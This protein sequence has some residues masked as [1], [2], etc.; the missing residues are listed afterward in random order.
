MPNH[1]FPS[2]IHLD[3][4]S[5]DSFKRSEFADKVLKN[6]L[7]K[8]ELPNTLG[9]YGNW[10]S[11]KTTF[12]HFLR[13]KIEED[14]I[15]KKEIHVIHFEPWKYEY[16]ESSDLLFAL[17]KEI[18]TSFKLTTD[19]SWIK[20]SS[21]VVGMGGY[22]LNEALSKLTLGIINPLK[23][24][25]TIN[26]VQKELESSNLKAFQE[27][28]DK[29]NEIQSAF[30]AF[31]S[32]G[33]EQNKKESIYIF[34][35]DLDRCLPERTIHLLES[36]KNFLY[37]ENTLFIFALDHRVVSEMIEKK[38][39]LHEG[40][41]DEYL[42]KIINYQIYLPVVS[43]KTTFELILMNHDLKLDLDDQKHAIQFLEE[44]YQEPR[45]AKKCIQHFAMLMYLCRSYDLYLS[46]Y[47]YP[48]YTLLAIYLK[49]NF[50]KH[51]NIQITQSATKIRHIYSLYRYANTDEEMLI[52][53]FKNKDNTFSENE[54]QRIFSVFTFVENR[55]SSKIIDIDILSSLLKRI[56]NY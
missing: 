36:I 53:K 9:I 21:L 55:I 30:K 13:R 47:N 24:K 54:I 42:E 38:Y 10:G 28:H 41:G 34:I 52:K 50:K 43:L 23:A 25:D 14:S 44:Y 29:F 49:E 12:L 16:S 5:K 31:I 1:L 48:I 19:D 33:L 2:E 3:D 22:A 4:L 7:T 18:Q 46:S 45:K 6:I 37:Q 51:F 20:L 40:Y 8:M 56:Q 26:A 27:W 15:L 17:L 39:G 11:G 35:D 32:N